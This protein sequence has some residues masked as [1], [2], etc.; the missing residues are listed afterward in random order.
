MHRLWATCTLCV[1]PG[2]AVTCT[3]CLC[4]GSDLMRVLFPSCAPIL[5][6]APVPAWVIAVV[7]GTRQ[8]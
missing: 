3:Q 4:S 2:R 1:V 5:P 6:T 7:P 8:T